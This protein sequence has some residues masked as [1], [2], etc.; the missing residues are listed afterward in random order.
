M[1]NTNTIEAQ[2]RDGMPKQVATAMLAAP[3][4]KMSNRMRKVCALARET[5]FPSTTP[6]TRCAKDGHLYPL[7]MPVL[8]SPNK[9]A[10]ITYSKLSR[11]LWR[12]VS[13]RSVI[14]RR[15][16]LL[17][18]TGAE[19][20]KP[21]TLAMLRAIA[22]QLDSIFEAVSDELARRDRPTRVIDPRLRRIR[23]M[24]DSLFAQAILATPCPE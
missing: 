18:A 16:T 14:Q 2:H 5:V 15:Y 6:L 22:A 23:E 21:K 13:R 10:G 3:K 8:S 9:L 11:M 20:S 19:L 17:V 7:D 4:A 1:K 24:N 12:A